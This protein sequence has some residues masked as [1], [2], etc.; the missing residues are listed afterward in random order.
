MVLIQR[1]EKMEQRLRA[2]EK[3]L[4]QPETIKDQVRYQKL[5]KE[6]SRC[7]PLVAGLHRYRQIDKEITG[8]KQ[9]L[10]QRNEDPEMQKLYEE[11]LQALEKEKEKL[12]ESLENELFKEADPNIGR[13]VIVEIRAGTGGEEAALFAA[14]LFRMYSRFAARHN[15]TIE[16]MS[17]NPTAIGGFKEII[18]GVSGPKAYPLFKYESGIHRVQRVPRTEASGRIHTS[19]V[20]VAVLAEA[21]ESEIEINPNDLRIDVFRASGAGGQHVNKTESAVRITHLPTGLVVTCQDERS[22]H[23]NKA[24]AFRVLR[25]RLYERRLEQQQKEQ[26]QIRKEQVG[27][28]DR[29]GK[30]RTYNF[31]DQRVTDHRIGLTLHTLDDILDGHLDEFVEALE[32]SER[33]KKLTEAA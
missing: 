20:T 32:R 3:E 9:G 24:K 16:V 31:P 25:A 2:L 30:I 19:A 1:L 17:S 23:K 21:D 7:K 12:V 22:Q 18:F 11:E 8:V 15:Q 10:R 5:M 29:S 14:D 28:G 4:A 26:A 33:L 27:T 6:L 13:D